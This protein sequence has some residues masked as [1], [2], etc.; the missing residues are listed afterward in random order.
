MLR[1][2]IPALAIVIAL[3]AC[4]PATVA[5]A[6][7]QTNEPPAPADGRLSASDDQLDSGEYYETLSYAGRAGQFITI[8]LSSD[9]FD[10]YLM[11][12]DPD[13]GKI[14][15][16][17]D[18]VGYGTNIVISL[19][20][21]TNGSYTFLVTS[22]EPGETGSFTLAVQTEPQSDPLVPVWES[23]GAA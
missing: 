11:V 2:V 1:A 3:M 23:S 4:A 7:Q 20:L 5:P 9:E 15:E 21:P 12:L 19:N 10:P 16:I 22:F 18:S 14:A 13:G 6:I 8:S 17:D